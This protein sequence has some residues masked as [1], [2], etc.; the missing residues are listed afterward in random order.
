MRS[1]PGWAP[2]SGRRPTSSSR[3][4]ATSVRN[5][6]T[7][8]EVGYVLGGTIHRV[9][10]RRA[11]VATYSAVMPYICP[12]IAADRGKLLRDNVKSP[13]VYSKVVLA[14]WHAFVRA[15]V[16]TIAAPMS[17]HSTVKLDYPVSLGA[18]KFPRSPDQPIGLQMVHVPLSPNQGLDARTQSRL[19][20]QRL[21]EMPFSAFEDKIRDDL[22]RMLAGTG[23]DAGRDVRA[24][25]VNRWSHGYSYA[26]NSLYDDVDAMTSSKEQISK[27][28]GSIAFANSD[29]G[30]DAYAHVAMTEGL[31]AARDIA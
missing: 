8:V 26:P 19:G 14:N 18:Y 21:I 27:K 23:F 12:D 9:T 5:V 1:H 17:F 3:A 20:R 6:G 11:I 29:T 24:I 28:I 7:G 16:H 22:S 31:R 25:T 15:G 4:T 2:A 30:L 13:L 10:A